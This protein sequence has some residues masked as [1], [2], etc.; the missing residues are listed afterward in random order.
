L[1]SGA[2]ARA[3]RYR[4]LQPD[5]FDERNLI[6]LKYSSRERLIACRNPALAKL[7]TQ[8][9]QHLIAATIRELEKVKGMVAAGLL[10]GAPTRS[11]CGS[12]IQGGQALRHRHRGRRVRFKVNEERVAADAALDGLYVIRTSVAKAP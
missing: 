5:L 8:E 4:H 3:C 12:A 1:K 2:I 11:A 9:R 10:K 6:N 7:H